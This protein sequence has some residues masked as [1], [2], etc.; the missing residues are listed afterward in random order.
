MSIVLNLKMIRIS[1]NINYINKIT[2]CEFNKNKG[3]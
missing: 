1:N 2:K 3:K